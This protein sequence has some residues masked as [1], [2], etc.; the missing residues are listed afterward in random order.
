M[1]FNIN[2]I[3]Y[4]IYLR[5][6]TFSFFALLIFSFCSEKKSTEPIPDDISLSGVISTEEFAEEISQD[7]GTSGGTLVITNSNSLLN[8]LTLTVPTRGYSETRTYSISSAEI[9]KHQLGEYFNP[10][11]PLIQIKNGGGY[12]EYPMRVR[13]PI[14][15]ADD[16]FVIGFFYNEITGEIEVLPT[17]DLDE[18][19]ITVETRHFA[20]SN[21]SQDNLGKNSEFGVIGNLVISS[22]KESIL[23]GQNV[24]SSGFTPGI[25]DWE[26]VNYGSYIASGGHCAGQ[27]MTAMWY[28]YEKRLKG[29]QGLFHL[30]D[31]VNDADKPGL[32]W[33]DNPLGYRFAST[34]QRDF[35]WDGWINDVNLQSRHP[36]LTYHTFIAAMLITGEPQFVIIKNS[37]TNAGHAM[38]IYKINLTEGKLYVADPNYPNNRGID[39]NIS[40]RTIPYTKDKLGP[41]PSFQKVGDPGTIYDQIAIF[42]KTANIDWPKIT[43]RYKE[44]ED[45]TIGNDRFPEYNLTVKTDGGTEPLVEGME[46]SV[47]TLKFY[48]SNSNI[49]AALPGT[50]KLQKIYVYNN[51]GA[52]ISQADANGLTKVKLVSGENKLGVYICGYKNNKP[53]KYYD[54]KWVTVNYK[55][56]NMGDDKIL[57][58]N[59]CIVRVRFD[60][61]YKNVDQNGITTEED[62]EDNWGT[63]VDYARGSFSG[64]TFTGSYDKTLGSSNY[65][66]TVVVTLNDEHN[67]VTS[68]D[69][70]EDYTSFWQNNVDATSSSSFSGHDIPLSSVL[71]GNYKDF[72]IGEEQT[73]SRIDLLEYKYQNSTTSANQTLES[74]VCNKFSYI[75]VS[76]S[77]E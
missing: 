68:V 24:I 61:H 25:D 65:K 48:C 69:W 62:K 40:V 7:I 19:S 33:Q 39:G 6:I 47:D 10:I 73:C 45:G 21:L 46:V 36:N 1:N 38:I 20:L 75:Q 58:N 60:G 70:T 63:V 35:D 54:F 3:K 32:L 76:F 43:D 26:F 14:S 11:S 18:S 23:A 51:A 37:A 16:E 31:K 52:Y 22:I 74:H 30:F 64:N 55:N 57:L 42:G 56:P 77:E 49:P 50:D 12:S 27:S 53:N 34:I 5:K 15:K 2:S 13:I 59:R 71:P 67:L 28:F 8:G 29:E 44:F 9:S 17:I 66:G 72:Q 4:S 41:Y